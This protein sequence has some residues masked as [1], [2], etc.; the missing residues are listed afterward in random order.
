MSQAH[1]FISGTVQGVG[2]RQF[3]KQHAQNLGLTG[4]VRN[5][6]DGGVEVVLQGDEGKIDH[7]IDCCSEGPFLAEIESVGYE[8]ED[9]DEYPDEFIIQQ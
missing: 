5:T 3:I 1:L 7:M 4:Y 8:W 6:E 9:E 2:F